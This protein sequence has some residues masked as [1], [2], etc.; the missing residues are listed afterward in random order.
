MV[1]VSETVAP[2]SS[3]PVSVMVTPS[4]PVSAAPDWAP[5][6]LAS[7]NTRPDS[8]TPKVSPKLLPIDAPPAG[9][10]MPD[11]ALGTVVTG[12]A[13]P[14]GLPPIVPATVVPLIVVTPPTTGCAACSLTV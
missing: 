7:K 9:S 1:V 2:V 6:L 3:V 12:V 11:T 14:L 8:A 5:S 10:T 13:V 4:M